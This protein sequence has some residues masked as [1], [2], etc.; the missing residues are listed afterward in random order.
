MG[1]FDGKQIIGVVGNLV[2]KKG[3]G[4]STIIQ[5]KPYTVKQTKNSKVSAW[6]FGKA[7][8]LSKMLRQEF[9]A[10]TSDWYDGRMV[11]RM[12]TLNRAILSHCY[13]E[14]TK[15]FVFQED[16]FRRLEGFEFNVKSLFDNYFWAELRVELD[17]TS[18]K[19]T[20]PEFETNKQLKYPGKANTCKLR[21]AIGLYSFEQRLQRELLFRMIDIDQNQA[22]VPEQ[23]FVFE[24]PEGCFCV[25]GLSLEYF[26]QYDD[27]KTSLNGKTLGP[28]KLIYAVITPG[29][30]VEP[31]TGSTKYKAIASAWKA[32][33]ALDFILQD[34]TE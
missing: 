33:P 7:S 28:A 20:I 21:I 26:Y 4:H 29:T 3:I 24:V 8:S 32:E 10:I 9:L 14:Q 18:L 34:Q 30:F 25:L 27:V 1:K 6:I 2:F 15:A 11:N 5:R 23:E 17:G 16:S 13:N 12:N 19:L 22:V 31:P